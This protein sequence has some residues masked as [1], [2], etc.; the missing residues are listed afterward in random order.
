MNRILD[1]I[2]VIFESFSIYKSVVICPDF[3]LPHMFSLLKSHDYPCGL[4]WDDNSIRMILIPQQMWHL[5]N[6]TDVNMIFMIDTD[7]N[8]NSNQDSVDDLMYNT[9]SLIIKLTCP[10]SFLM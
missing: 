8:Q 1:C 7:S 10:S 3:I 9:R 2:D 6:M 5:Y 4:E